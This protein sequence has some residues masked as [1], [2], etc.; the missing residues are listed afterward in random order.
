MRAPKNILKKV[1]AVTV[2]LASGMVWATGNI[3][4][5]PAT[6]SDRIKTVAMRG[7]ATDPRTGYATRGSISLGQRADKQISND[8]L[9]AAH[10]R[11]NQTRGTGRQQKVEYVKLD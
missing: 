2:C 11:A 6:N 1:S 3:A 10:Q 4:D 9:N 7:V 8:A 5:Q